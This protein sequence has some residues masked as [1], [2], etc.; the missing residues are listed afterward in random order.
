MRS[1][2]HSIL[3]IAMSSLSAGTLLGC[4]GNS[5][6][7]EVGIASSGQALTDVTAASDAGTAWDSDAGLAPRPH[8]L[9]TVARVDVHVAGDDD[10]G[11]DDSAK[12]PS[13]EPFTP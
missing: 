13:G 9:L 10:V 4:H 12:G 1:A 3:S 6:T 8:L 11:H 5:G 7:I 2:F